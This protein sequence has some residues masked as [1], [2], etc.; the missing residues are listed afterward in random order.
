MEMLYMDAGGSWRD[1]ILFFPFCHNNHLAYQ[2]SVTA[3]VNL[4]S[5]VPVTVGSTAAEIYHQF[6]N[7]E[8]N[9]L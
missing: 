3:K 7:R 1:I 8:S 6:S 4:L 5:D 9:L 2:P